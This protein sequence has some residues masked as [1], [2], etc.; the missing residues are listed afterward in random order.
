MIR[1]KS[2]IFKLTIPSKPDYISVARLTSSSISSKLGFS[3]DEIE[4]IKV[5]ISEACTNAL[6]RTDEINIK[7]EIT[8]DQFIITVDDVSLPK[9]DEEKMKEIHFGILI[10]KSLMDEVNFLEKGVEMIKYLE[11]GLDEREKE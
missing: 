9:N 7:F 10:M 4:D 2:D 11:D 6:E 3:I 8:Q 1:M 5:C